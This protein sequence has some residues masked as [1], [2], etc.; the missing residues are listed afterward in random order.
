M[1]IVGVFISL[2]YVLFAF[3]NAL[4]PLQTLFQVF[5]PVSAAVC[6]SGFLFMAFYRERGRLSVSRDGWFFLGVSLVLSAVSLILTAYGGKMTFGQPT[7]VVAKTLWTVSLF[8]AGFASLSLLVRIRPERRRKPAIDGLIAAVSMCL[9][10]L[11]FQVQKATAPKSVINF[12]TIVDLIQPIA[13]SFVLFGGL[14]LLQ[15]LSIGKGNRRSPMLMSI[16]LVI[17]AVYGA[18][19]KFLNQGSEVKI[20]IL[21]SAAVLI[22]S[23]F[24]AS[25]IF[26]LWDTDGRDWE[27]TDDSEFQGEPTYSFIIRSI[28]PDLLAFFVLAATA[29]TEYKWKG[30]ISLPI[31]LFGFA[32][33]ILSMVRQIAI[34]SQCQNTI[35]DNELLTSKLRSVSENLEKSIEQR[36]QQMTSLHQLTKAVTNTLEPADVLAMAAVHARTALKADALVVWLAE[37]D[38]DGNVQLNG[39]FQ[40]GL[41]QRPDLA[42]M[43]YKMHAADHIEA[44]P[45]P[46]DESQGSPMGGVL[47]R[48]PMVGQ[49]KLLGMIGAVR[50]NGGFHKTEWEMLES[51]GFETGTALLHA[52]MF[53]A[54]VQAADA[55]PV[56]GLLNHRAIHQRFDAA[57]NEAA[58]NETEISVI[59]MDMNNF[60]LFNDTYGHPAGDEALRRVA[61][62]LAEE[63]GARGFVGRYGGDEFLAVLP[64]MDSH[65]TLALAG[66]VK[67][68]L[69]NEGFIA[70]KDDRRVIP[71]SLSFGIAIYPN[72]SANRHDL[73]TIADT[74][75][76]AAKRN[77]GGIQSTTDSQ[78][79]N[80]ELKSEHSFAVLD[81]MVTAVDNKDSYT[82]RHSED[83][84][85]FSLW[86]ADELGWSSEAQRTIRIG[87]L[88]HDVGKICVPDEILRK[89]GRLTSEEFEILKRH[90]RLGALIVGGVQGM[91]HI[92]DIVQH[93]HERWDGRGY[94]DELKGE[95]I[96]VMGRLVAIAD[97][98]SAM[99]T[100][101][102][103]RKGMDYKTALREIKANIGTL[104]DPNLADAFLRAVEKKRVAGTL[105]STAV[106]DF[107]DQSVAA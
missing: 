22:S 85:E 44:F 97:T 12:G 5:V 65:A 66:R 83:V 99:T 67:M 96:P 15:C 88:L 80:R 7:V 102:P 91:E 13:Y 23:I 71:I 8:V 16:S 72:D 1:L 34:L 9:P 53:A 104:F 18:V 49:Q 81:G 43:I 82:R 29:Y 39:A 25:S 95:E 101:R 50:F 68:R 70:N 11:Y 35:A 57:L 21:L 98:F 40:I 87:A 56:T 63:C 3:G 31:F 64:G 27:G 52:R 84:A 76:Y 77:G 48:A 45:L 47:L 54:A 36:T 42:A 32:L 2:M 73:I 41:N 92:L 69:L 6:A 46:V 62:A 78:R 90:P 17:I 19:E 20:S 103:Y 94:P 59:M 10:G 28:T 24:I 79:Q 86:I 30:G 74:N 106:F 89:P 60:K 75:L 105:P 33:T 107:E 61:R 93:H 26:D 4:G 58:Q 37:P 51:I 38:S 55:D 100:D 14:A